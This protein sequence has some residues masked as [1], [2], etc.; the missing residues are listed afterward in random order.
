MK[1]RKY[2]EWEIIKAIAF[3]VVMG[4][5]LFQTYQLSQIRTMQ[6]DTLNV[7]NDINVQTEQVSEKQAETVDSAA[8]YALSDYERGLVESVVYAESN[9]ESL[10]GQEAVAQVILDRAVLWDMSI[11][12]VVNAPGQF[13][14]SSSVSDSVR[15]AV[16]N[17]FD[18][19]VTA[20]SGNATHFYSGSVEP[21]WVDG[22]ES[23]GKI[24]GH[25]FFI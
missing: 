14:H 2:L 4:S 11:S 21:Y 8:C 9:G 7:L 19:G 20:L 6:T 22:K 17:V 15:L 25:K 1:R 13:A 18:L 3:I 16:S 24:G 5:L 12:E 10:L 23:R